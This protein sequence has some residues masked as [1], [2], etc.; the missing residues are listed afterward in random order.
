[1]LV[2]LNRTKQIFLI[3]FH[4]LQNELDDTMSRS[5]TAPAWV[6][7]RQDRLIA[8][9]ENWVKQVEALQGITVEEGE[10]F[11]T[12]LAANREIYRLRVLRYHEN[13]EHLNRARNLQTSLQN[14]L[15]RLAKMSKNSHP[16]TEPNKLSSASHHTEHKPQTSYRH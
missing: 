2:E 11:K 12:I 1:M 6:I 5:K 14:I 3:R 7:L 9:L 8:F 4:Q 16:K 15:R 10:L 13:S